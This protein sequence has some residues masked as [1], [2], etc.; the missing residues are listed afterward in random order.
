VPDPEHKIVKVPGIGTVKFP[1][2]MPDH[3]VAIAIRNHVSPSDSLPP[4]L[5]RISQA[6]GA[7]IVPGKPYGDAIASVA[8]HE[9]HKI[10]INDPARFAQGSAQTLGH[11]LTHL[12][13]ANLSGKVQSQIPPDSK[14]KPYDIS[15]VDALRAK[16]LKLWQLPQEQAATI[17]QTYVADPSQRARLGPW[18]QDLNNAP[19]SLVQPTSPDAKTL[20]LKPRVPPPPIEGYLSPEQLKAQAA[21]LQAKF[22]GN[23]IVK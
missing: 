21:E 3:H 5:Q 20:N 10:E 22:K 18:I 7:Q 19:L 15:G 11:E 8:E 1:A 12:L 14:T 23:R 17:V 9:P 4:E 16:G 13:M 6:V 2:D